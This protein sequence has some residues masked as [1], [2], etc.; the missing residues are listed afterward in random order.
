VTRFRPRLT[1]SL[2]TLFVLVTALAIPL[3]YVGWQWRIVQERR[4]AGAWLDENQ[5]DYDEIPQHKQFM[6]S[7]EYYRLPWVRDLLGDRYLRVVGYAFPTWRRGEVAQ[8]LI[9]FPEAEILVWTE[10][11]VFV[12][13]DIARPPLLDSR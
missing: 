11:D 8:H 7:A 10:G 5:L 2:R 3:G 6:V 12:S 13:E 9:A 4:E 1:F